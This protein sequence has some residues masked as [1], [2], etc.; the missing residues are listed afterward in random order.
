MCLFFLAPVVQLIGFALM[1][2]LMTYDFFGIELNDLFSFLFAYKELF[3]ILS[4]LFSILLAVFVV[5]YQKKEVR[6][7]FLGIL[8]FP[9]F[10]LTW[11]PINIACLFKKNITWEPIK[12]TRSISIDKMTSN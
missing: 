7:T 4:Y 11:I 1:L 10:L 2:I 8:T 12:H 5:K 9:F 6:N 3:F